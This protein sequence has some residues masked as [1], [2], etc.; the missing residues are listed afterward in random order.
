MVFRPAFPPP[1]QPFSSTAM[2][3]H[4][5]L[6]GQIV[7]GRKAMPAAADD[8]RRRMTGFRDPG[9]AKHGGQSLCD[10]CSPSRM[11]RNERV[12]VFHGA[13]HL[14]SSAVRRPQATLELFAPAPIEQRIP[15]ASFGL[16]DRL[17]S[18][19][20]SAYC[21]VSLVS[22]TLTLGWTVCDSGHRSQAP[23]ARRAG[24]HMDA[25]DHRTQAILVLFLCR[26]SP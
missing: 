22:F 8:D 24:L 25:Y 5:M 4:A 17:S 16:I 26:T 13:V 19:I 20:C 6:F 10:P 23:I 7:G 12:I 15:R 21:T 3:L 9:D 2:L 14:L 18:W 11:Q 1:I